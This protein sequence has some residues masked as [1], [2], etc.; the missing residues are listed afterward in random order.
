MKTMT[1]RQ[2]GGAC[3]K[4]FH[5]D[6]FEEMAAKSRQHGMEMH[7]KHDPAHMQAMQDMQ[8]LMKKPDAMGKWFESKRQEFD[9]LPE[10]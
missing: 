7:Q 9:R 6:T 10:Q 4:T 5:A 8:E 1:C 3:E 2:L